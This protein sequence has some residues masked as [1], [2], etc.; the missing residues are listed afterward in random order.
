MSA[1]LRQ[2][3]IDPIRELKY[4]LPSN[5]GADPIRIFC[6]GFI[7]ILIGWKYCKSST[8]WLWKFSNMIGSSIIKIYVSKEMKW[9]AAALI[10]IFRI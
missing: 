1:T 2:M 4:L 3:K 6:T 7:S 8:N 5:Q 10:R 9:S